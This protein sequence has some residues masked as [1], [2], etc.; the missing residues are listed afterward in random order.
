MDF[1]GVL[2]QFRIGPFTILDTLLAYVG[3]FF[4]SPLLS[5][6]FAKFN[7]SISRASWLW[8]TLPIGIIFHLVFRQNTPLTKMFLDPGGFYIEKIVLLVMLYIGLSKIKRLNKE[9]N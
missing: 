3:I 5:R 1:I 9:S 2:R 6:I 4:V 8:L 7:I